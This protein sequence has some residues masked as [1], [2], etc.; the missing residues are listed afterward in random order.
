MPLEI[1][2][3]LRLNDPDALRSQL[4]A[5]GAA[6]AGR[7]LETNQLLDSPSADLFRSGCGLRVR[8]A[9]DLDVPGRISVTL[10]Y[11]GPRQPGELKIREE[12]ETTVDDESSLLDVLAALGYRPF[13]V[14]EKRREVWRL[15]PCEIVI[16]QLPI[17]GFFAEIEGSTREDVHAAA[18]AVGLSLEHA[19][20][21]SYVGLALTQARRGPDGIRRLTF[22]AD[23]FQTPMSPAP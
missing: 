23:H 13:L 6:R 17:L 5:A 10:T 22:D 9:A 19:V 14:F 12:R 3:K 18:R 11:K 21:E 20:D 8:R 16:D 2:I 1:E 15:Q 7:V 4:R